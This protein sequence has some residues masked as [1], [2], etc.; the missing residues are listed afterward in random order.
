MAECVKEAMQDAMDR[1]FG[2]AEFM[3]MVSSNVLSQVNQVVTDKGSK[4][5]IL[6]LVAGID[7][8]G[9]GRMLRDACEMRIEYVEHEYARM[10]KEAE[11]GR[12]D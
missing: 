4:S 5:E 10:R 9:L 6:K 7:F 12:A 8:G 1:K 2:L 11:D 3:M